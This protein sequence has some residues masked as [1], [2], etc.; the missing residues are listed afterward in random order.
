VSR[1]AGAFDRSTTRPDRMEI[2]I[3]AMIW[4]RRGRTNPISIAE[5]IRLA[6]VEGLTDR[7]VK[8][9]VEQLVVT[10]RCRIGARRDEPCGYYWIVDAEDQAAAVSPYKAQILSMLRR[11]RV[12]DSHEDYRAFVGQLALED[13]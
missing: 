13:E 8:G 5:I 9:V 12:L 11:L 3:A 4:F 1:E 2:L 6:G 7:T 10:H